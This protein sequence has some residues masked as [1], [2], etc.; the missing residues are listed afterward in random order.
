[1]R[2]YRNGSDDPTP[3]SLAEALDL[4]HEARKLT[5]WVITADAALMAT[6]VW[7]SDKRDGLVRNPGETIGSYLIR[8]SLHTW[9]HIGEVN[10]IRQLLGHPEIP[11]ITLMPGNMEWQP[12]NAPTPAFVPGPEEVQK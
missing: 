2:Q 12:P 7:G 11:F 8:N 1:V 4:L 10:M 5:R 9:Y 6:A 3:P